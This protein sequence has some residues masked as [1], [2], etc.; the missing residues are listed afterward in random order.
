MPSTIVKEKLK[1]LAISTKFGK[2]AIGVDS[3]EVDEQ[4]NAKLQ[5]ISFNKNVNVPVTDLQTDGT[6][7]FELSISEKTGKKYVNK[8]LSLG[9]TGVETAVNQEPRTTS[10]TSSTGKSPSYW[11]AKD[12]SQKLGGLF[13]DAATLTAAVLSLM[14]QQETESKM[15]DVFNHALE[16]VITARKNLD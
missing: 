2:G 6:Y 10:S 3:G 11:A 8:V 4:G 14:T 15:H 13:H 7:E 5:F 12:E 16:V 1:V 9:T